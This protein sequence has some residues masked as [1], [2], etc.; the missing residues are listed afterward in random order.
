MLAMLSSCMKKSYNVD[1]N[2]P[3]MPVAGRKVAA[4]L[5][6]VCDDQKCKNLHLWLSDLYLFK[7][8]YEVIRKNS[9]TEY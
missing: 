2:L 8:E 1:Y 9:T 3:E 4:E 5:D 6:K 7:V